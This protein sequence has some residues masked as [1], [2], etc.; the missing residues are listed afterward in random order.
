M[1]GFGFGGCVWV[2]WFGGRLVGLGLIAAHFS[3][4]LVVLAQRLLNFGCS[5]R[6]QVG[7]RREQRGV[8]G[9]QRGLGGVLSFVN[10]GPEFA[11]CRLC[12]LHLGL[13]GQLLLQRQISRTGLAGQAGNSGALLAQLVFNGLLHGFWQADWLGRIR[14]DLWGWC[15]LLRLQL[16]HCL[17]LVAAVDHIGFHAFAGRAQANGLADLEISVRV[18]AHALGVH[19]QGL[20]VLVLAKNFIGCWCHLFFFRCFIDTFCGRVVGFGICRG[21]LCNRLF[22]RRLLGLEHFQL[23]L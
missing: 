17:E 9:F 8:F 21:L 2:G 6:E 5:I 7:V 13:R 1:L 11:L 12:R 18:V 15:W 23:R 20:A 10:V 16:G 19:H 22:Q 3:I 14:L 4:K